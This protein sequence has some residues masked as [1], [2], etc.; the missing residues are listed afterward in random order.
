MR[1]FWIE[2]NERLSPEIQHQL[3]EASK[4]ICSAAVVGTEN[5][6][7]SKLVGLKTVSPSEGDIVLLAE[8]HEDRI[9]KLK[10]KGLPTAVRLVVAKGEDEKKV[11]EATER[12]VD[13]IVVSCPDW[14]II[15]LENLIAKVERRSKL[16]TEVRNAKEAKL[17]LETLELGADGIVLQTSNPA[18]IVSVGSTLKSVKTRGVEKEAKEKIR[19]L[20]AK[21]VEIKELGSGARVCID[22]CDLMTHG[23]GMLVGCQS[24]GLFLIQA[25]VQENPHVEPR[26]FRVNAGPVSLYILAPGNKTK[27][28]S[29]LRA[30]D[31]VL[32]VDRQGNTRPLVVGRIKIEKRPMIL[33]EAETEHGLLKLIG[34]NAE[35]IRLVTEK[36]ATPISHIKTGDVVLTYTQPG[37]RHFGML[38]K[39]ETVIER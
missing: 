22:T 21:V 10:A 33:L 34:Q 1:E 23:E 36:G 3:L 35:T 11:V 26:P 31:E 30:G 32:A 18:E 4:G 14:K 8:S 17:A 37:G 15:P 12:G 20:S 27:Y 39:E 13:Y 5:V 19:L 9:G 24:A 25:E 7:S 6:A 2:I 16:L 29:E 28:L 38:V